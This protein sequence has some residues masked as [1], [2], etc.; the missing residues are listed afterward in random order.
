MKPFFEMLEKLFAAAAFAEE[1][2]GDGAGEIMNR[3]VEQNPCL[4][5]RR[6][7]TCVSVPEPK[8]GDA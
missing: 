6:P 8:Y 4:T 2:D 7:E 1:G 5:L 3:S